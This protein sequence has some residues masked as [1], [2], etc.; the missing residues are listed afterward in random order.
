M[1]GT[2]TRPQRVTQRHCDCNEQGAAEAQPG[3]SNSPGA[4]G[5][6]TLS[7]GDRF[8]EARAGKQANKKDDRTVKQKLTL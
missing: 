4:L 5:V 1:L 2:D 3:V 8:R 6:F 7:A